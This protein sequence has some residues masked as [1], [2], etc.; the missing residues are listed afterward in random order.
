MHILE[1]NVT[2][3]S[4]YSCVTLKCSTQRSKCV[5]MSNHVL[6]Y[7]LTCAMQILEHESIFMYITRFTV[8]LGA[9]QHT[10]CL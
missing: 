10:F 5:Y 9:V 6:Q 1:N 2:D 4:M 8:L 7:N 3:K